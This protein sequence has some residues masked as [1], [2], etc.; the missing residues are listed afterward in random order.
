MLRLTLD[1]NC[2]IDVEEQR[3]AAPFIDALAAAHRRGH[4]ELA[5]VAMSASENGKTGARTSSF[6]LFTDRLRSLNL[7]DLPHVLPMAYLDISF[8]SHCL[9][10]DA[11]REALER[12]IHAVLFRDAEFLWSDY[13]RIH[14]IDPDFQGTDARWLNRKCDVQAIWSHIYSKRD[15]FVTSDRNFHK[16]TK[17]PALIALGAS[18]IEYPRDACNLIGVAP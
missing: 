18:R 14:G 16:Q 2:L 10:P 17:K 3:A 9:W 11:A 15:I 5:I 6:G 8:L 13:S 7:D 4:V 1:T 12:D